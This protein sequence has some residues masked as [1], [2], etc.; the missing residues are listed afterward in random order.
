MKQNWFSPVSAFRPI[1]VENE[2]FMLFNID[3]GWK[4]GCIIV[5]DCRSGF[6]WIFLVLTKF[7]LTFLSSGSVLGFSIV[8]H[9]NLEK[10]FIKTS[11]KW[12]LVRIY[13]FTTKKVLV[14]ARRRSTGISLLKSHWNLSTVKSKSW[15]VVYYK[16]SHRGVGVQRE[17]LVLL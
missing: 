6:T 14:R 3:L 8:D 11:K 4:G 2:H 1:S 13:W 17:S 15:C 7:N 12:R 10:Q 16:S 9:N 5:H